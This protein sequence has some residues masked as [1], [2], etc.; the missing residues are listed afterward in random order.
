MAGTQNPAQRM[1]FCFG[2]FSVPRKN[3]TSL[4]MMMM[5][6]M[7]AP[8]NRS[9]RPQ[10]D[11]EGCDRIRWVVGCHQIRACRYDEQIRLKADSP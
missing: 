1:R 4:M 10:R 3:V 5:M 7:S 11:G 9:G 6:M 8:S 2:G